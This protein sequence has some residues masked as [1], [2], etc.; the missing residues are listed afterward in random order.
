ML[1]STPCVS[2]IRWTE[3]FVERG[4]VGTSLLAV[5]EAAGVAPHTVSVR[6]R[7]KAQLLSQEPVALRDREWARTSREAP[8]LGPHRGLRRRELSQ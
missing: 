3:L 7:S 2:R 6:F 5:A 8:T 4:Y 1:S